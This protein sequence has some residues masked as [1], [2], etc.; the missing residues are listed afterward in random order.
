MLLPICA[1][2]MVFVILAN[3]KIL[4]IKILSTLIIVLVFMAME[5][6]TKSFHFAILVKTL[7]VKY[8]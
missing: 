5:K 4:N 2:Y 1:F 6:M 3:A 8:F 7:F